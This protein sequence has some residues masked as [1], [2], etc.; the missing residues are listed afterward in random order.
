M[1]SIPAETQTKSALFHVSPSDIVP[2]LKAGT[3]LRSMMGH[4]YPDMKSIF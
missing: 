1:K 3:A 2:I 4:V